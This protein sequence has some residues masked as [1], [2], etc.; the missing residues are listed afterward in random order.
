MEPRTSCLLSKHSTNKQYP[1][2][3][4]PHFIDE[5]TEAHGDLTQGHSEYQTKG[6]EVACL[7]RIRRP[8][9]GWALHSSGCPG[10]HYVDRSGWHQTHRDLPASAT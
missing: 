6:L 4:F 3:P 10:T 9:R 8:G 5:E 7:L 2:I 1:K